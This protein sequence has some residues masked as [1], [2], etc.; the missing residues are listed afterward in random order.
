MARLQNELE[1]AF[2]GLRGQ[3]RRALGREEYPPVNVYSRG[4]EFVVQVQLP[5]VK[6]EGIDLTITGN[7]LAVKG[8]RPGGDAT[9]AGRYHRRERR[10]GSFVRAIQLP[11]DV[12]G[13][14]A[15]ATYRSGIL[16]VVLPRAERARPRHIRV[17]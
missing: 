13:D 15:R 8:E 7:T 16:T 9:D 17:Q 10:A 2:S 5:G 1:E 12:Q 3:A 14:G 6:Q 4:N 11:E